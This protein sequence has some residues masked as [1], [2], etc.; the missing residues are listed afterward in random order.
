MALL[1]SPAVA[2]SRST[3]ATQR[4][5]REWLGQVARDA[6]SASRV[7]LTVVALAMTTGGEPAAANAGPRSRSQPVS[8]GRLRSSS[9]SV[10]PEAA[11]ERAS[12]RPRP[13]R[14]WRPR[15]PAPRR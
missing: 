15:S 14:A 13:R 10:G 8:P 2:T 3:V 12:R 9:T 1:G 11:V 7:G 4:L 5:E 6:E